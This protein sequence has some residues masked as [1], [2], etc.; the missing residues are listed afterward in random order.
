MT[1]RF[2][3]VGKPRLLSHSVVEAI[4]HSIRTR[5]LTP[6]MKL[7]S[8]HE[9]CTQFG[10]SRTV[11]REA[12]RMLAARGLIEIEKGRGM[13]ISRLSP[14]TVTTPLEMYL[15]QHEGDYRS[16]DIIRARQLIEPPIAAEAAIRHTDADAEQLTQDYNDMVACDSGQLAELDMAFHRHIAVA[17]GNAL[18]PLLI[19]P[20]YALM[21]GIKHSVHQV[22]EEARYSAIEWHG[23]ILK[24]I[25]ARDPEQARANM[26]YHLIESERHITQM[27][28]SAAERDS[29]LVQRNSTSC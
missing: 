17:C 23:R 10:V 6:G 21:P 13:F 7:D 11:L 19:V 29:G 15:H 28:E 26:E 27:M 3:S 9:L 2:K 16:I 1:S 20:I 24:A 25:L 8:E 22:I 14:E 18:V 12:L 4:E 5:E